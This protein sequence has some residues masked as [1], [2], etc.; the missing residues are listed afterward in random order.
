MELRSFEPGHE[1]GDNEKVVSRAGTDLILS[2]AND[3]GWT[4]EEGLGG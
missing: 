4:M 2:F 3:P 1:P